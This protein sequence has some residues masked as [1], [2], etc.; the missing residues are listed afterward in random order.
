[1][2]DTLIQHNGF[3]G[4]A[5]HRETG[6]EVIMQ[7]THYLTRF[8]NPGAILNDLDV[9]ETEFIT[10]HV[11]STKG[12]KD[13]YDSGNSWISGGLPSRSMGGGVRDL[14]TDIERTSI[15]KIAWRK[16]TE[17]TLL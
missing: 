3:R 8:Q 12:E 6:R 16:H 9:R 10:R 7:K 4:Q 14:H 11:L 5:I 2:G 17:T 15:V 1:M 13:A